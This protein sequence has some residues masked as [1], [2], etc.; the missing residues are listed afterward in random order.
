MGLAQN[1]LGNA[2]ATL[3]ERE[4]GTARLEESITAFRAALAEITRPQAP[5]DWAT[6]QNNLGLTLRRSGS[7]TILTEHT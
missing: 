6:I 2:L 4:I 3:G 5:L 7:A 1:D